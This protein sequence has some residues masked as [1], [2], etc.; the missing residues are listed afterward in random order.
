MISVLQAQE[1]IDQHVGGLAPETLPLSAAHGR[2]LREPVASS[3]DLPSFDR[4]AMDGYA[5]RADDPADEFDVVDE[6]RA[7]QAIDR[8]IQPG[9][10]IRIFTGARLPG[11]GLKV[12]IQEHVEAREGR[13]RLLKRTAGS[14]VRL[15]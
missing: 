11:P 9:Q 7:G 8:E 15:R 6:V 12:V 3:E 13:I 2:V 4:S 5:V 10:A 14:N 1:L